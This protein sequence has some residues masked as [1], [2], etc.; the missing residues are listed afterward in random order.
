MLRIMVAENVEI[1][2]PR[3][4]VASVPLVRNLS[5]NGESDLP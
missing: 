1:T 3:V 5:S 4:S 2:L